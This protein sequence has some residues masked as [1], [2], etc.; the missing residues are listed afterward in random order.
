MVLLSTLVVGLVRVQQLEQDNILNIIALKV[1]IQNI[2]HISI[3]AYL[4]I[5]MFVL[6][7]CFV[8]CDKEVENASNNNFYKKPIQTL[9][10]ITLYKSTEGVVYAELFSKESNYYGGDS[11]RTVFPKGIKVKFFNQ[12][13]STKAILTARYAINYQKSSI[14]YIKDSIVII[15]Y[16]DKDTIYC[17][18]LYWN[19]TL[20]RVYTNNPIRRFSQTGQDF[21]DGMQA[22][23]NFDSVEIKNPHGNELISDK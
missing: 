4:L 8:A 13:L 1:Q 16:N 3:R 21:G 18:D 22:S 19:Q 12:D 10:D 9:K 17:R 11:A 2:K 6:C 23:E 14:V 20:R 15:N 5:G 7:F